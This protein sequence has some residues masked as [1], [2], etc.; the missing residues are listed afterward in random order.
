MTIEE[1]PEPN[2]TSD[3]ILD[4]LEDSVSF[5]PSFLDDPY[6]S[7][8]IGCYQWWDQDQDF[9]CKSANS[10]DCNS[11]PVAS[12]LTPSDL[13]L[14][15]SDSSKKRKSPDDPAPGEACNRRRKSQG[16][17]GEEAV[18]GKKSVGSKKGAGKTTTG[19]NCN[20][21][22]NNKEQDSK[23]RLSPIRL[24]RFITDSGLT[25]SIP[26]P[27]TRQ[28]VDRLKLDKTRWTRPNSRDDSV[29]SMK[30]G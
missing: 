12:V 17:G 2:P 27:D 24:G 15:L 10:T 14:Q 5:L 30:I 13:A 18:A 7:G 25:E 11:V 16:D 28:R 4:W 3:H 22:N 29:N 26:L 23:N 9:T 19:N 21:G 6:G 1:Q 8:N 20:N